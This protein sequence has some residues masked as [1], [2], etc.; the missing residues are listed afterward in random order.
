[1]FLI[2]DFE[3]KNN[4]LQLKMN[5]I[6]FENN[7]GKKIV[8]KNTTLRRGKFWYCVPSSG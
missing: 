4:I 3:S 7:D 1:M 6:I 5:F 2:I 8:Q